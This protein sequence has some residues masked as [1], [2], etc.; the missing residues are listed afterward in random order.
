MT[1]HKPTLRAALLAGV[2]TL[3]IGGTAH[4][5]ESAEERI[6]RL[7]A[8]L[9]ELQGQLA[10]LK[11]STAAS[12][13]QV[14]STQQATTVSLANGRPTI[15]SGDGQFTA[16][17]RGVLQ[18][19]AAYYDQDSAGPLATDFRRGSFGDA[20]ENDHARDLSDGANFR[21][22]RL[23][24]EGKAFGDFEYNFLYDFG[25]SGVEEG[26]KISA[27]WL[28]YNGLGWAKL[29]VGAF[30]PVTSL[31]DAASNASSLFAERASIAETV[32]GL[33]GGDGRTGVALL[34]AG[35]RWTASAAITGNLIGTSTYDEQ[36]GFVG[37]ATFVPYKRENTLIHWGVNAN[38]ILSPA[39]NGPDVPG[40]APTPIR[41]RDRPELRVDGVRLIDTGNID[42]D[43]LT[44]LG[45]EF[46]AQHKNL[47]LQAEYFTIEL[48][49]RASTLEDPRFSGWYVQGGWIL[50][51]QSR[52]YNANGGFDGPRVEKPFNLKT[53]DWGVWELG[54]RYSTIDLNWGDY[55]AGALGAIQ[56]GE[57][58]ILS[59]GLNWYLNNAVT[60]QAAYRNVS[61]DRLSPG[62]SAFGTIAATPALGAQVGQDLNIYSFRTQYAF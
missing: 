40:G 44:A 38:L 20:T 3:C 23:G 50:T 6:A 56:G 12:V 7:E 47:Y 16:S 34:T 25:G 24:I 37:R 17:F 15:A 48:E 4:A 54:V 39:A 36:V 22:V 10:D 61:V 11:A 13:Q 52:R 19:D 42:A 49:R 33:A 46:G 62:G 45:L 41:L 55:R 29:R 53:G 26:G 58:D 8:A 35:E 31:E 59:I 32:R 1:G 28:Q 60:L 14:R 57:Q 18:L 5:Q 27:A 51:G 2:A 21:R 43:G 30:P 9:A